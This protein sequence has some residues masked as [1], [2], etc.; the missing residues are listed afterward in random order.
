MP[1]LH[2]TLV[3]G[4][5]SY[6]FLC[7]LEI[8]Q[9]LKSKVPNLV[10]KMTATAN[11]KPE[12][13]LVI[14][15]PKI[16][17]C[18]NRAWEPTPKL[19]SGR[20]KLKEN[21]AGGQKE[22]ALESKPFLVVLP[23]GPCVSL[24]CSKRSQFWQSQL[25]NV[26]RCLQIN[27]LD[28]EKPEDFAASSFLENVIGGARTKISLFKSQFP[29]KPVILIGWSIGALLSCQ[30]ATL[31]NVS[32]VVCLGYPSYGIDGVREA[33]NYNCLDIRC[34]VMFIIGTHSPVCSVECIENLR[35]KMRVDTKMLLVEGGDEM[36]KLTSSHMRRLQVT[37]KM[38]DRLIMDEIEKFITEAL[39]TNDKAREASRPD[40]PSSSSQALRMNEKKR[41]LK[42][43][44]MEKSAVE[45]KKVR[46]SPSQH[47]KI[48]GKV[49]TKAT[50]TQGSNVSRPSGILAPSG[51]N[52]TAAQ[53]VPASTSHL[54]SSRTITAS[55]KGQ[56]LKN[57]G[58]N[59]HASKLTVRSPH[60]KY[61]DRPLKKSKLL[62]EPQAISK[63]SSSPGP[64]TISKSDV[65][66][67]QRFPTTSSILLSNSGAH[68]RLHDGKILQVSSAE[69]SKWPQGVSQK[70]STAAL[71]FQG[72]L[73][74]KRV[75]GMVSVASKNNSLNNASISTSSN[76]SK[77]LH[78]SA[79]VVGVSLSSSTTTTALQN[80]IRGVGAGKI[81]VAPSSGPE[82]SHN[83][84]T[85]SNST[86]ETSA[87]SQ[88]SANDLQYL[89]DLFNRDQ[90]N[91]ES[92]S[93]NSDAPDASKQPGPAQVVPDSP[94]SAKI[95][96]GTLTNLANPDG[97]PSK[98]GT[99]QS[100]GSS[101]KPSPSKDTLGTEKQAVKDP[102]GTS[103]ISTDTVSTVTQTFVRKEINKG[104]R[105]TPVTITIPTYNSNS[106]GMAS[107]K[108]SS[109][110]GSSYNSSLGHSHPIAKTIQS[111]SASDL[112]QLVNKA[113]GKA[114]VSTAS[115]SRLSIGS[116][117]A[118]P[119]TLTVSNRQIQ[120]TPRN[121]GSPQTITLHI[122]NSAML[123]D[124]KHVKATG[125]EIKLI[126]FL[127][128]KGRSPMTSPIH[129]SV[130]SQ[131]NPGSPKRQSPA[132][133]FASKSDPPSPNPGRIVKDKG[134]EVIP[135]ATNF[136][137]SS[138]PLT[139]GPVSQPAGPLSQPVGSVSQPVGSG[140]QS[141]RASSQ[142]VGSVS[143]AISKEFVAT[144]A[145]K[146]G[147]AGSTVCKPTT[148]QTALIK[149]L[150]NV[151]F[152][153]K[154]KESIANLLKNQNVVQTQESI[155]PKDGKTAQ[156]AISSC[157]GDN[158]QS[159][160]TS[161]VNSKVVLPLITKTLPATHCEEKS[162]NTVINEGESC[163]NISFVSDGSVATTIKKSCDSL[164]EV[165]GHDR[166]SGKAR[167]KEE[168]NI[169]NLPE[170]ENDVHVA[171]S[172]MEKELLKSEG[173]DLS[174]GH[175]CNSKCD[176]P[177]NTLEG[178][179]KNLE[180]L[181]SVGYQS[182]LVNTSQIKRLK[183][184]SS[185]DV[186]ATSSED[187]GPTPKK[188]LTRAMSAVDVKGDISNVKK[189][190]E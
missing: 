105:S 162:K 150:A 67:M 140:S 28:V 147:E 151:S 48:Q 71:N 143:I 190:E 134:K 19:K 115:A 55:H 80:A 91:A 182:D 57:I 15:S 85:R 33:E 27:M 25:G 141:V 72:G 2:T 180:Q 70:T 17:G 175:Q 155:K 161:S 95:G 176:V 159:F 56:T 1:W 42:R 50:S 7:Y 113:N 156:A 106:Q 126:G 3:N 171:V 123:K 75:S 133:L 98:S 79:N 111:K 146:T 14:D 142:P 183:E 6:L 128:Q 96:I 52:V 84:L 44:D 116:Q 4:L 145:S 43:P 69:G 109:V 152:S 169:G 118:S 174:L 5:N 189:M 102:R 108:V 77:P 40:T 65:P 158:S 54:V 58:A 24:S 177:I 63:S 51:L 45:K 130:Q 112:S 149:S 129:F 38:V 93:K 148:I 100:P 11:L 53:S 178:A 83:S 172:K 37:Q 78:D 188:R 124:Q 89:T 10:D 46:V 87:S 139:A 16:M 157:T 132:V 127:N 185:L 29:S 186:D 107:L 49:K 144:L 99:R 35:E 187:I 82:G 121:V 153:A 60:L 9:N 101:T 120:G 163:G 179:E 81:S 73:G 114:L 34:P 88:L 36:L 125:S 41:K 23:R 32:G 137:L 136:S 86:L 26:G 62:T 64:H 173:K 164:G 167:D 8:L 160:T 22:P 94:I 66:T 76:P 184:S 20:A 154:Q 119:A 131:S 103:Q 21:L 39:T 122:P 30:I 181:E 104:L 59:P 135:P 97:S 110:L 170:T 74:Y 166:T 68:L 165:N 138:V 18:L 61:I 90:T 92:T 117:V 13:S 47:Q 12:R 168:A 31:E